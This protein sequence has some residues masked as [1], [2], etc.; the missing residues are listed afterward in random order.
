MVMFDS[1]NRRMLPPYGC[2]WVKAP[3]FQRLARRTVTFDRSY[4]CSMPCMPARRDLHT[5]RPNFLHR[6]WGPI[7]PF[8]DSMPQMLKQRGVYTHLATDHQHYWEDGGA[9]YHQRYSTFEFVRGQEGDKWHPLVR[10]V[11]PGGAIGRNAGG[12]CS[13]NI[14]WQDRVNRRFIRREEDMPQVRTFAAGL[15]FLELNHD[16]DNWLVQIETFDPHE[17]FY[18]QRYWKDQYPEHFGDYD[19]PVH[20]WPPYRRVEET[21]EQVEHLR[22]E[23]AALVSMCDKQL[24]DVLDAMD[25]YDL[26]KDT[27]LIV[28]TDHGFLLGEHDAWAKCWCPFY[29]EVAHTP[30]FVWD[31]RSGQQQQRRQALVQPS[32]DLPVTLLRYFGAEPTTDMLGKDLAATIADDTPVRDAAMYGQFGG[33]VNVTDGR[34]V[35]MATTADPDVPV[36]EYTYMPTRMKGLFNVEEMGRL[37]GLAEPFAFTKG[38]RPMKIRG[39]AWQQPFPTALYDLQS[40]P[41]Q[42]TPIADAAVERR[43]RE[44]LAALMAQ[45]DAPRAQYQRL[46]LS[47]PASAHD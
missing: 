47:P 36:H 34:Y 12:K 5:G 16:Q 24:G 9:T 11:E 22:H 30:F 45:C 26:W 46:G 25:R 19:G 23:Y 28:W 33:M 8:D 15:R 20:D 10:G 4:V 29:N 42:R 31:P 14:E 37:S 32:I 21:M 41:G 17:P 35:L 40:D 13:D 39:G 7:E 3:N 27:M 2:D 18:T 6:A 44:H 1:L 38:C 43:L